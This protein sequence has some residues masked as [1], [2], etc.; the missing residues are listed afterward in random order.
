[1]AT[2]T[3]HKTNRDK[4]K[5]AYQG[6]YYNIDSSNSKIIEP[7]RP[8]KLKCDCSHLNKQRTWICNG[9]IETNHFL[10]PVKILSPHHPLHLPNYSREAD[11]V[12]RGQVKILSLAN[13]NN[14]RT[15]IKQVQSSN[16]INI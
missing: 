6:Y 1:M 16:V 5:L 14:P 9:R 13:D 11:I 3:T 7:G 4:P 10:G 15:I 2:F 12:V 8:L